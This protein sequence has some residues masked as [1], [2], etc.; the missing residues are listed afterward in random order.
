MVEPPMGQDSHESSSASSPVNTQQMTGRAFFRL[1]AQPVFPIAVKV[2]SHFLE[3]LPVLEAAL[4]RGH[5]YFREVSS[6]PAQFTTA[7]EWMLD[8]FVFVQQA[9]HQVCEDLPISYQR[10]LPRLADGPGEGLPRVY[11]LAAEILMNRAAILDLVHIRSAVEIF[12]TVSTLDMGELWALPTMLRISLLEML[13]LA[14]SSITGQ[15]TRWLAEQ[16]VAVRLPPEESPEVLVSR[17]IPALRLISA[18]DWS[19]FFEEVSV[20]ECLL[21]NDPAGIY[22]EM[23]F[24]TLDRYRSMIEEL[25]FGSQMT[26]EAVTLTALSLAETSSG[27]REIEKHV[28]FY[29]MDAG[30]AL[31]EKKIDFKPGKAKRLMNFILRHPTFFYLGSIAFL[32]LAL[33]LPA[34]W[35]SQVYTFSWL[36][37]CLLLILALLLASSM[38][39][40]LVNNLVTQIVPPRILP[41]MSFAKGIPADCRTMVA[42]PCMLTDEVEVHFFLHQLE[43]HY[44]GNSD[45]DL[46][47]ALLSDFRDAAQQNTVED[48]KILA[49]AVQGIQSLNK[50]YAPQAPE[51]GPFLLFHRKRLWND[52]ENCWMGWERKRGKLMEFNRLIMGQGETTYI[53]QIGNV[54]ILP[55]IRYVITLDADT[56]MPPDTACRLVSTLAHPLNQA[57]LDM[58]KRKVTRGYAILQPRVQVRPASASRTWLSRIFTEDTSLDLYT[59]AVSDVY[60]DLFNEGIYVGKGIYDVAAFSACLEGRV[61]ENSLLSHDLFE[62]FFGRAGLV[63]DVLLMENF[64]STYREYM[65]RL[66]RWVRG[67]WQLLPWLF[68]GEKSQSPLS[69]ID[70]WQIIDN[71]LR[72][73]QALALM[74]LLIS[75]WLWFPGPPWYWSVVALLVVL[76]PLL[77]SANRYVWQRVHKR[78]SR[79]DLKL[80]LMSLYRCLLQLIFLPY[81]ALVMLDAISSVLFRLWV[82]HKRLLQWATT[83]HSVSLVAKEVHKGVTWH[84]FV[85]ASVFSGFLLLPLLLRGF[86]YLAAAIPLLVLWMSSIWVAERISAPIIVKEEVLSSED[87]QRLREQACRTWFFFE[88]FVGPKDHWLPPDHFQEDPRGLVA[89]RTSPT[90]IGMLLMVYIAV[91]ELGYLGPVTLITRLTYAQKSLD[92]L[93]RFNGHLFNWYNT[94]SLLPLQ[95]RY[96]SSV[97]SGNLAASFL[98]LD[99]FLPSLLDHDVLRWAQFQALI[100]TFSVLRT[101]LTQSLVKKKIQPILNELDALCREIDQLATQR[102]KWPAALTESIPTEWLAIETDLVKFIEANLKNFEQKN[103]HT[104]RLWLRRANHQLSQM[105]KET[106]RLL[107]W[108]RSFLKPPSLFSAQGLPAGL[109]T[110][111]REAQSVAAFS[112]TLRSLLGVQNELHE[113]LRT[114]RQELMILRT[115]QGREVE[116]ALAWCTGLQGELAKNREMFQ[117][118]VTSLRTAV[119]ANFS[120]MHFQFLFDGERKSFHIGYNYETAKLDPNYYDLMASEAR[121]TSFLAIAKGDVPLKHWLHLGRPVTKVDGQRCLLSWSATMFEYLMPTLFMLTPQGTLLDQ[122]IE[123]AVARQMNYGQRQKIPWGISESGYYSFDSQMNYQY[124]AFGVPGLGLKRGL[125]EDLVITPY[126]S[127][128]ALRY[129]PHAVLENMQQ[130]CAAGLQGPYGFY[131]ALDFTTSRTGSQKGKIVQSYMAHHQG[132]IM[133]ALA[134]TLRDDLFV[135]LFHSD[136]RVNTFEMLLY[137]QMPEQPPLDFPHVEE[138]EAADRAAP[139]HLEMQPWSPSVNNVFPQV[140]CLSNDNFTV[141]LNQAGAGFSR[142][143]GMDIN[144]WQADSTQDRFGSWVYLYD[145]DSAEL[146]S[147]TDQPVQKPP[148]YQEVL[149]YPHKAEYTRRDADL[150]LRMTIT[151][152]TDDNVE[153]RRIRLTNNGGAPRRLIISSYSE[154]ILASQADDHRH[155]AFNKLFIQGDILPERSNDI[156]PVLIF[157][158]RPRSIEEPPIF[159]G[160]TLVMKNAFEAMQVGYVMDREAFLGRHGN[161]RHPAFFE[162]PVISSPAPVSLDPIC[163]LQ[164]EI[165]IEAHKT[166]EF[167]F[168]TVVASTSSHLLHTVNQ[169]R[170]WSNLDN[171]LEQARTFSERELFELAIKPLEVGQFERL[172][173]PLLYPQTALRAAPNILSSNTKGQSGLWAY[174]ISGDNPIVLYR[175]AEKGRAS[176]LSDLMRAQ[177]Y[178]RSKQI[179]VDLVV[180]NFCDTSYDMELQ[181][182]LLR[183]VEH[184]G[185]SSRLNCH[186]GIF[187][188]RADLMPEED[189]KLLQAA[190]LAVFEAD[191]R[192]FEEQLAP[193][194]TR[195]TQYPEF[196]PTMPAYPVLAD[197]SQIIQ[198]PSG[199]RFDNG[200]GGFSEDGAEYV[201]YL[202]PGQHTPAPWVNV[203]ANPKFGFL[204]SE[205]GSGCTWA[206]NSGENRLTTWNNDPLLDSSGEA[207]YVR[208]EETGQFWSPT[209]LPCPAD[210]PYLVHHGIGYSSFEHESHGLKSSVLMFADPDAPIKFVRLRLESKRTRISRFST[211]FYAEWVLGTDREK[212]QAYIQ[213]SFDTLQHALLV[214]NPYNDHFSD[215]TAFLAATR[216]P[217][218]ITMDRHEFLGSSGSLANPTA[219]HRFGLSG[220]VQAGRDPC[221]AMQVLLW[222][223]PGE[224][225]EVT[226]LL[227]QGANRE[228]ALSL[229][230]HYQDYAQVNVAWEQMQKRWDTILDCVQVSTPDKAMD[231]MLNRWLL[232]QSLTCRMWGRTALYQSS[233]AFGFRDQLQDSLAYLHSVPQ[234]TRQHLLLACEHQFEEGDVLHWWHPPLS[235]GVRTR[236]SDDLLWLPYVTA[237]Y[238]AASGDEA[239]LQEER[240]F[241][242]ADP[243]KSDETERYDHYS[244]GQE[245]ATLF[246]HCC[247]AIQKADSRGPHGLPLIGSHDWNDGMNRV[248]YKGKGESVWLAWFFYDTLVKFAQ[249]CNQIGETKKSTSYLRRAEELKNAIDAHAWDGDWYRRAYFDDG[250]P[251]GSAQNTECQIDAIAQS[252]AVISGGADPQKAQQAMLSVED[253]LVKEDQQLILLFT[254]PFD[255]SSL[256]PGYIKGYPPGVRENGGQYTHAALWTVWALAE[257]GEGQRAADLFRLLNPISHSDSKEKAGLYQVEPYVVAADVY[258][259]PPFTGRGGWTWYTGSASWMYRLGIEMILGIRR[260]AEGLHFQPAIPSNWDH[261]EVTYRFGKTVYVIQVENP[262]HVQTG[263][264]EIRLD[265]KTLAGCCIPWLDDGNVHQITVHMGSPE[266]EIAP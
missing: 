210:A 72:S 76:L 167:A 239:I 179:Q 160:H 23:D 235:R 147:A 133:A 227:G 80:V 253:Q 213:P 34:W 230:Q 111:W 157:K 29:L 135:H 146:W 232:Y 259:A 66:H 123:T 84:H 262:E 175:I 24:E 69:I 130:M 57:V 220:T 155:P 240:L 178:W 229:I 207:L 116:N 12:Q 27:D 198:R 132:M 58:E 163:A 64:P 136:S 109:Q 243:L 41:K 237:L 89:H 63:T 238:I 90:N 108:T 159:F 44:L 170:H 20:I 223:S 39:V 242:H 22:P 245:T 11:V 79:Q 222:L 61:M 114:L 55:Q 139:L 10:Q 148:D 38:A 110:A 183:V 54:E 252:W 236:C 129:A 93:E 248:G 199:L 92:R 231:L 138:L 91:Y 143:K 189:Q 13:S 31:L 25:T 263:V 228:E 112:P 169:Y 73:L 51:K 28:G 118:E 219:L 8:N 78:S 221:A 128:L 124:K 99:R 49:F 3:R 209:P 190:A 121:I 87:R 188:L 125:S 193:L 14:I 94:Q 67:D 185:A 85:T 161:I 166:V 127:L 96:I 241:L 258:G 60:Q 43:L 82:S 265:R 68:K 255:T 247:R 32:T 194:S 18:T 81:E 106:N 244:V 264:V 56:T 6:S 107:P 172:L 215:R 40:V 53:T 158:R 102:T 224:T 195:L 208:D 200:R 187:L 173:S 216:A 164:L 104:T 201:M 5:A 181:Q 75:G 206:E 42:V 97:D 46:S 131:E 142:W 126:A 120:E 211:V 7:A 226:F 88:R 95:P 137:E 196:F 156:P 134:N 165:I 71:L 113:K 171:A 184:I 74:V 246:E 100:D 98:M 162:A 52:G 261:Y 225:K 214:Q 1:A 212:S 62:S 186:G 15:K 35:V 33:S 149:F 256:E 202:Q 9:F 205:S 191:S 182:S 103:L 176:L 47:F 234:L 233:G 141:V 16:D 150:V 204:V 26:E 197:A 45:P 30:R 251:L 117:A 77:S 119:E 105:Q 152:P 17:I 217:N 48:E 168:L 254:P 83:R 257:A 266:I 177:T 153:I 70:R 50:R 19:V 154:I 4:E 36:Q 140:H 144:R 21:H 249:L 203:I 151:V 260:S 86:W 37:T 192:T 145:M 122:S 59:R 218:G 115:P 65:Q 180:L 250:T 2:H 174:G 101:I